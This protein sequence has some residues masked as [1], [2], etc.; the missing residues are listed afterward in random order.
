VQRE[1]RGR[2]PPRDPTDL[3]RLSAVL[4]A[5]GAELDR[6]QQPRYRL[7]A[8]KGAVIIEGTKGYRRTLALDVLTDLLRAAL[9]RRGLALVESDD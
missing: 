7:A 1:L 4:R 6:Q 8:T 2:V 3:N 9:G 5:V